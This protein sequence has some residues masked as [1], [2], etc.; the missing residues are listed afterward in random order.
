EPTETGQADNPV[1]IGSKQFTENM[2]LAELYAI[3]LE[4]NGIPVERNFGIASAA[5]HPAQVSGEIDLYPEYTGTGLLSIL[6]MDPLTDPQE[7]YDT[8]KQAFKSLY[9]IV[10][11]EYSEANDGQGI[12]VTKAV[13]DQYGIL[14]ISDLQKNAGNIRFASQGMFDERADGLPAL[15]AKYGP[16]KWK[17]SIVIDNSLKYETLK[18]DEA[19]AIPAYTSEGMLTDPFFVLL[20]DD[21][22]V[23]PPYNAAPVIR[24]GTLTAYPRIEDILNAISAQLD[25]PKITMLNAS[26]DVEGREYEEVAREFYDS[27][28]AAIPE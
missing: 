17:S 8:V 4:D 9:D 16:F 12:A 26:V 11:L 21:K 19:D 3:A 22:K 14:T 10:W 13:S 1:R 27:V 5:I 2:I 15:E 28:K 18:N 24:A 23:W 25:T 20:E 7:V 6:Q